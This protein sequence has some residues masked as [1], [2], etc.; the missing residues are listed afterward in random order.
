MSFVP[1]FPSWLALV[2][3]LGCVL[4]AHAAVDGATPTEDEPVL[5]A[6]SLVRPALLSGPDFTVDPHVE[7][8]GYMA[9][10][11]IDTKVGPLDAD[12]VEILAERE[13]ELPAIDTLEKATHSEAFA[14]AAGAKFVSTGKMLGQI[15][16]H[17][18]DTVLG[19]PAGVARYFG[20]KIRKYATQAQTASDRVAKELGAS[21]NP[22]PSDEGPMTDARGGDD[23]KPKKHWYTS[24]GNEARREI[25]RQLK[26][27]QVKRE[28]ARQLGIDPYSGNPYVQDRLSSL[29]WVGSGGNFSA[30]AA[31]GAVGGTGAAVLSSGGT[32]ND[33]V[34]K[35]SPDD[36]RARNNERL[37][38]YCRDELLMRQ[39]L[40]RG[41]FS[42]TLQTGLVDSL[43]ALKPAGG[44]DAL[45]ELGMTAH[46]ELESRFLVNGLRVTAKYLGDRAHGGTLRTVGAGLVYVASDGE[47]VLPL[48]VD[49]LSWTEEVRAF[50]DREEFRVT[51][52]TVL[53]GGG[54]SLAAR[55][56]LTERGW[57]IV[58][59]APWHGSPPY[60][61]FD[62]KSQSPD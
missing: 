32:I 23:G 28:L 57:N 22:Y 44:G 15:V 42:P 37:R 60:A 53:I 46:S 38:A 47:L 20:D 62:E 9:H 16:M 59:R 56:G 3:G 33:V 25:K 5:D 21:G 58:V 43:D 55:R 27:S 12:S 6:A 7:L 39:F 36:L 40:R 50:L 54:A 8:R 2:A 30:G 1:R 14:R 24:I 51:N 48:P 26:Y 29:A 10:F 61:A 18:V 34:W 45:L 13:A 4:I 52:K 31:L 17:P 35:L 41:V 19:I 49:Y 11:T